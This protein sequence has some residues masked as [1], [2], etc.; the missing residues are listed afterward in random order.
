MNL[1]P[2]TSIQNTVAVGSLSSDDA[3]NL[4]TM[5]SVL[6]SGRLNNEK[7][8]A[9][10]DATDGP[11]VLELLDEL[12]AIDAEKFDAAIHA[13]LK[14]A[15]FTSQQSLRKGKLFEEIANLLMN[16]IRCFKVEKDIT[17][18]VNQLDLLVRMEPLSKL[19]P[20]FNTWN[21]H[22]ICECKFH[23]VKFNGDW[24]DQ[25]VA[26]LVA[27]NATA[28]ILITKKAASGKGRGSSV[29]VKL[30]LYAVQN[31]MILLFS[32]DELREC[33]KNKTMLKEIVRKHVD[34][35]AG[36]PELLTE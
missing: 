6:E 15:T 22:F 21:A 17:T 32:R 9:S 11:A 36:I 14:K 25:L 10:L 8:W 7:I 18:T 31:R 4:E 16:G 13:P 19:V 34:V 29:T 12:D 23:E 24:I 30:Q 26:I 20:A 27:Q 35:L 5:I 33:A 2:P 28:G 3:T 1:A